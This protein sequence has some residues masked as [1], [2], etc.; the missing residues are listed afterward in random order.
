VTYLDEVKVKVTI[1]NPWFGTYKAG[2]YMNSNI[3]PNLYVNGEIYDYTQV[4]SPIITN[5]E[6][7]AFKSLGTDYT[8]DTS[9]LKLGENTISVKWNYDKVVGSTLQFTLLPKTA[10]VAQ[11]LKSC[12]GDTGEH[13]YCGV[14]A[15]TFKK[16]TYPKDAKCAYYE[17]YFQSLGL[18]TRIANNACFMSDYG[19]V[20]VNVPKDEINEWAARIR[21]I[22]EVESASASSLFQ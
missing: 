5:P 19:L 13:I 18:K 11:K 9:K 12:I 10:D 22:P 8:I 15:V 16:G 4:A 2:E 17:K 21:T 7:E 1:K 20:N 3:K 14:V 6:I